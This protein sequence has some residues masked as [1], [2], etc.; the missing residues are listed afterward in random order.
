MKEKK[1]ENCGWMGGQAS[2]FLA[3]Y[4]HEDSGIRHGGVGLELGYY[5]G[6]DFS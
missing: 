3:N 4:L 2:G 5:G 6:F 1:V